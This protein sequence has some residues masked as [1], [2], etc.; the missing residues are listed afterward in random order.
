MY[1]MMSE[2]NSRTFFINAMMSPIDFLL[3]IVGDPLSYSVVFFIYVILAAIILPIPVEIGLFNPA[4]HPVLLISILAI[5]KGV[6]AWMVFF[7]G[8]GIHV[9]IKQFSIRTPLTEKILGYCEKFIRKYGYVGLFLLMSIPLMV[10][11]VS[12][13]FFALLN[14]Q[15]N[16]KT[17]LTQTKFVAINIIAGATRGSIILALAYFIGIQLV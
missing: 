1:K 7:I 6:G 14:P 3:N 5:G 17:V 10:D 12:L 2:T 8:K 13:Y 9:K 4:I 15:E 16:G 11:S